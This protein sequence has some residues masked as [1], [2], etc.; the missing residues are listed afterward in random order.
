M[1]KYSPWERYIFLQHIIL[2]PICTFRALPRNMY[3]HQTSV[4]SLILRQQ[5]IFFYMQ[6]LETKTYDSSLDV[7]ILRQQGIYHTAGDWCTVQAYN[8][9]IWAMLLVTAPLER[10]RKYHWTVKLAEVS[11]TRSQLTFFIYNYQALYLF[12]ITY[13]LLFLWISICLKG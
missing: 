9:A 4:K 6:T 8:K 11:F 5:L 1:A 3:F 2:V 7:P 12:I 10:I 13:Q